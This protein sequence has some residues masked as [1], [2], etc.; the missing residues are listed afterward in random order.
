LFFVTSAFLHLTVADAGEMPD[1]S[2]ATAFRKRE[3]SRAALTATFSA[4]EMN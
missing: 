2:P 1:M 3:F 4:D